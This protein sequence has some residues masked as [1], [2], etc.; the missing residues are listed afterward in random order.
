MS[1]IKRIIRV[2]FV[3]IVLVVALLIGAL[4]FLQ[5]RFGSF[6]SSYVQTH[7]GFTLKIGRAELRLKPLSIAFESIELSVPGEKPFLDAK[8]AQATIPYSSFWGDEFVVRE[9]NLD[10]PHVDLDH[11]PKPET[12][13]KGSGGP[14][15]ASKKFRIDSL[16]IVSAEVDMGS[17]AIQDIQLE[18]RVDSSGSQLTKMEARFKTMQVQARGSVRDWSDPDLHF[19]YN[20]HGELGGI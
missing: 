15:K 13:G 9:V 14:A 3:L 1:A 6:V 2:L 12:G 17:K 20:L 5:S 4:I 18:G 19:D 10:S 11:L 16:K 7:Y 8:S